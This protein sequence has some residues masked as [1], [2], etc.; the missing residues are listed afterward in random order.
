MFGVGGWVGLCA[1]GI[2]PMLNL[3]DNAAT[4]ELESLMLRRACAAPANRRR[5]RAAVL[6]ASSIVLYSFNSFTVFKTK[7][8]SMRIQIHDVKFPKVVLNSEWLQLLSKV[9]QTETL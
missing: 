6:A 1:D 8:V 2:K 7:N 5:R 9:H 3:R 4:F